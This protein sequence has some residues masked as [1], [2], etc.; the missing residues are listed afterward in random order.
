MRLCDVQQE[1]TRDPQFE[2][3]VAGKTRATKAY[4]AFSGQ[5]PLISRQFSV[6]ASRFWRDFQWEMLHRHTGALP[7]PV[8]DSDLGQGTG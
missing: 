4:G 1:C 7:A 6:I 3:K 2:Y 8:S 5:F